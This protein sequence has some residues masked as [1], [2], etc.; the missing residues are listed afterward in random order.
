ML[1]TKG[2]ATLES[3][4]SIGK[5]L[6][7]AFLTMDTAVDVIG[8]FLVKEHVHW[9]VV[10][11]RVVFQVKPLSVLL[12]LG[13]GALCPT[14]C[15]PFV[16]DVHCCQIEHVVLKRY[17]SDTLRVVLSLSRREQSCVSVLRI[18]FN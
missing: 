15:V 16:S 9:N 3:R 1:A 14:R 4:S 11:K 2:I 18:L 13:E 7:F 12:S 8:A 17:F 6:A 5:V 10:L